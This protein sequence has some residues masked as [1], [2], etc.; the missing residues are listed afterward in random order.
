[1][2]IIDP[3]L[4]NTNI[5]SA[6]CA[7]PNMSSPPVIFSVK[8]VSPPCSTSNDAVSIEVST[9][10]MPNAQ[11]TPPLLLHGSSRSGGLA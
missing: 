8:L 11:A 5:M 7:P 10:S 6:G 2:P 3:L 4:S 1:M 9:Y